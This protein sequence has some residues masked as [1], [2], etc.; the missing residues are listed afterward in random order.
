MTTP[1]VLPDRGGPSGNTARSGRANSQCSSSVAPSHTPPPACG[2]SVRIARKG[3]APARISGVLDAW[4]RGGGDDRV[5]HHQREDREDQRH[6]P[7]WIALA[8]RDTT[9]RAATCTGG[10][11]IHRR[12]GSVWCNGARPSG[13]S[14]GFIVS[15]P[16]AASPPTAARSAGAETATPAQTG[17]P[18]APRG[19]QGNRRSTP[20]G[21]EARRPPRRSSPHPGSAPRDQPGR[22]SRSSAGRGEHAHHYAGSP[23]TAQGHLQTSED[24][25]SRRPPRRKACRE[26]CN[27]LSKYDL[28]Q[29]EAKSANP[30]K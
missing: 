20:E 22:A 7:R 15:R 14:A 6:R 9:P 21:A 27:E 1:L 10:R 29:P 11:A 23:G 30:C 24:V 16:S 25:L 2:A 18:A 8:I 19:A 12:C 4:G 5:N 3:S 13:L 26:P 17:S 28:R